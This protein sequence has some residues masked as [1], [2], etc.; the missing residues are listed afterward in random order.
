MNLCHP[1]LSSLA[2]LLERKD[3]ELA[4]LRETLAWYGERGNWKRPTMGRHWSNSPAADDRGSR[5][6]GVLLTLEGGR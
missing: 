2:Q 5:A 4:Q 1:A 6:R 3:A